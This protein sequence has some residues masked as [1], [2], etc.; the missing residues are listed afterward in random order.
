MNLIAENI[1]VDCCGSP[2][3]CL[4]TTIKKQA[5]DFLVFGLKKW[6]L[7]PKSHLLSQE[8]QNL[9][10]EPRRFFS[11]HNET[12]DCPSQRAPHSFQPDHVFNH[13]GQENEGDQTKTVRELQFIHCNP[14]GSENYQVNVEVY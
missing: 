1:E 11:K 3:S 14:F 8:V 9:R 7:T 12:S 4:Q 13:D 2:Q 6:L 10:N 5:K